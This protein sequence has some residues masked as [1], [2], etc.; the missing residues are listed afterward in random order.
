MVLSAPEL[1]IALRAFCAPAIF[2]LACFHFPGPLLAAIVLTAFVSDIF[3]G[4]LARRLGGATPGLRYADTI[5]DTIFY[6]AAA[7][8]LRVA[9]PE[10]FK[11]AGLAVFTLIIV[12]VSRTTFELTKYGRIAS[13]HMWSSKALGVLIVVAMTWSF[14]T[15]EP[16]ALVTAALWFAI[17]NE[18]EGF[19]ASVILPRYRVDVP[20]LRHAWRVRRD[21]S[22]HHI[23]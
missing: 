20:T 17:A 2:V 12:H 6:V 22:S 11:G 18:I 5:V 9:V 13:Y 14:L 8:A 7:I 21:A 16:T 1:L 19:S 4:V 3:D 15:G 23:A 10:T